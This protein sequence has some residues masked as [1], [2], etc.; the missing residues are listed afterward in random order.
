MTRHTYRG[1]ELLTARADD[2]RGW[3]ACRDED[4]E[5]FSPLGTGEPAKAQTK[6]A[7]AVCGLCSV[8]AECLHFALTTKGINDG[9][10]GGLTPGQRDGLRRRRR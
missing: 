9:I 2:W 10:Y 1:T 3:A 5:L 8:R 7:K 4:P 6:K